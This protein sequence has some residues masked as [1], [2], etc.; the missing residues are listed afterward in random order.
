MGIK[1][2]LIVEKS[3]RIR[4]ALYDLQAEHDIAFDPPAVARFNAVVEAA[5]AAALVM[6]E[7]DAARREMERCTHIVEHLAERYDGN[8][9]SEIVAVIRRSLT[10]R[11]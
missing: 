4:F 7:V 11:P 10:P 1:E 8:M 6:V 5:I 9:A 2:R 3:E